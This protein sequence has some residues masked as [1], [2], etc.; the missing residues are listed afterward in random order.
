MP[1]MNQTIN[2]DAAAVT[3]WIS[4]TFNNGTLEGK[5]EEGSESGGEEISS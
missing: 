3:P 2:Q 1:M 4:H 5:S